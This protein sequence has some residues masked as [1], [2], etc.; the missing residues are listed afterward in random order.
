M[1]SYNYIYVYG[2]VQLYTYTHLYLLIFHFSKCHLKFLI[3]YFTKFTRSKH[4]E[5][6]NYLSSP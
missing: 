6:L 2:C 5:Q 4:H 3:T 1:C